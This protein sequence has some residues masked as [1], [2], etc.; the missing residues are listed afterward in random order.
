MT[1]QLVT[2]KVIETLVLLEEKTHVM[3]ERMGQIKAK[4]NKF[5]NNKNVDSPARERKWRGLWWAPR[6]TQVHSGEGDA[7][8]GNTGLVMPAS[9]AELRPLKQD[10][11]KHRTED[12]HLE[13]VELA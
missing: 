8:P 2:D 12:P 10:E 6:P 7:G 9:P 1:S 4:V 5:I 13:R 3:E 11:S